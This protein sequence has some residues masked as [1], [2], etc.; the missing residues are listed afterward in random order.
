[1]K[2]LASASSDGQL[3][4]WSRNSWEFGCPR[5]SEVEVVGFWKGD[6][7]WVGGERRQPETI[8]ILEGACRSTSHCDNL[9][10]AGTRVPMDVGPATSSGRVGK[11]DGRM[12]AQ[13]SRVGLRS[14]KMAEEQ[15]GES[16]NPF[17]FLARS[18][19][20]SDKGKPTLASAT[21][22]S[23]SSRDF[24]GP[25]PI[26]ITPLGTSAVVRRAVPADLVVPIPKKGA[27]KGAP[28]ELLKRVRNWDSFLD[29][30]ALAMRI[31]RRDVRHDMAHKTLMAA[32]FSGLGLVTADRFKPEVASKSKS[33]VDDSTAVSDGFRKLSLPSGNS[34]ARNL[35][36]NCC[37]QQFTAILRQGAVR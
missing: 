3:R 6:K 18:K 35:S 7:I 32:V 10:S 19:K 5:T 12:P 20:K 33:E 9:L 28:S 13:A 22:S 36:R 21:P 26:E 15:E 14:T 1:M 27:K 23:F 17:G 2:A 30:N 24:N 11:V 31:G 29:W 8:K 16:A 4:I 25:M 34:G 37:S